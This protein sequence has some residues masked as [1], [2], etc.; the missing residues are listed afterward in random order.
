MFT[1][2]RKK[3]F[4][5]PKQCREQ[6]INHLD[7]SKV[8]TVWTVVEDYEMIQAILNINKK[9][10]LVAKELGNKRTEH[11]VKNRYKSLINSEMKRMDY[12]EK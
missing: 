3:Y 2:S 12:D 11:M 8:R 4:R 5:T 1:E 9:W 10:S 7:P 6:W